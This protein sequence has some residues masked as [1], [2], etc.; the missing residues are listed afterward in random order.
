VCEWTVARVGKKR[1]VWLSVAHGGAVDEARALQAA[2]AEALD[3][4]FSYA[5][6]V[7]ASTYLH[8][9]PRVVAAYVLPIDELPWQPTTPAPRGQ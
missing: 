6:P 9:G 8:A 3:V 7:A 4:R 1:P 2:L 5:V